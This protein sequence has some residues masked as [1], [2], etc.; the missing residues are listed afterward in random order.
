MCTIMYHFIDFITNSA[1]R[2]T[3]R[4]PHRHIFIPSA[5]VYWASPVCHTLKENGVWGLLSPFSHTKRQRLDCNS[6]NI[7]TDTSLQLEVERFFNSVFYEGDKRTCLERLSL[8]S[9]MSTISS[10]CLP[11]TNHTEGAAVSIRASSS[12]SRM[13]W[14]SPPTRGAKWTIRVQA[15]L[16][17]LVLGILI[18]FQSF[19]FC[20]I[21]T[22]TVTSSFKALL[23]NYRK[24]L[25][26]GLPICSKHNL[27][28]RSL[29]RE[30]SIK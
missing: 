6:Y 22:R 8:A 29:Y 18:Y 24:V 25:H 21:C 15:G 5:N 2:S 13:S 3:F 10:T 20:T 1:K 11:T 9:R 27:Q 17:F 14:W 12:S 4:E 28:V 7:L 26:F 23:S 30:I 19:W 16:F